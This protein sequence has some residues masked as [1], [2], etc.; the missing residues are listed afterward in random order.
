[1]EHLFG[2]IKRLSIERSN[3]LKVNETPDVIKETL[4]DT[5]IA[6]YKSSVVLVDFWGDVGAVHALMLKIPVFIIQGSTDIQVNVDNAK[7]LSASKSDAKFLIIEKRNHVMKE[8]DT[9][10]QKNMEIHRNPDLPLK[11]GLVDEIVDF[12]MT[13]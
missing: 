6:N 1:M 9:D 8:S 4:I 13:K 3:D 11:S 10:I 12:I 5:I 7:I 2:T